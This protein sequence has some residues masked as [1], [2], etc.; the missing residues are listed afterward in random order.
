MNISCKW[1]KQARS[2]IKEGQKFIHTW[3]ESKS[4]SGW[5]WHR[6]SKTKRA[7]VNIS[8]ALVSQNSI[9]GRRH[10]TFLHLNLR[11]FDQLPATKDTR[12]K[13]LG[14]ERTIIFCGRSGQKIL[15]Q[16]GC[17]I[18]VWDLLG[19]THKCWKSWQMSFGEMGKLLQMAGPD[20]VQL[21][22]QLQPFCD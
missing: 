15:Q 13:D 16:T 6:I 9:E 19:C 17:I 8:E 11:R 10:N 14:K 1:Y 4:T 5:F 3:M 20:D 21:P 12:L 22:F 7:S 2:F 18:S